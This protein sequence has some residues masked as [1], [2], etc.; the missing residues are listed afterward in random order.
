MSFQLEDEGVT[1]KSILKFATGASKD[2]LLGFSKNPTI[3]FAKVIFPSASTCINELVLP[4]EI[5]DYEFV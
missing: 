3:Q 4:V 1:I 2:P 5:V